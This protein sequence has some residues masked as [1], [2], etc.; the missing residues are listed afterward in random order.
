M[1]ALIFGVGGQDGSYLADLLL[2]KG[3]EVHG[4]YRRTS[5]DNLWRVHH[6]RDSPKLTLHRGDIADLTSVAKILGD[7]LPDEIYNEADQ[8]DLTWSYETPMQSMEVTAGAVAGLL[9][10]TRR[11][12]PSARFFQ[13]VSATMFGSAPG[14][15]TEETPLNPQSPYACA[16]AC[17]YH[18]ARFYR[19]TYGMFVS[20]GILYNHDSPRRGKGRLL[21]QL[22]NQAQEV[23]NETRK[24][25]DVGY[26]DMLVDIGYAPEYV[27]ASWRILKASAPDDFIICSPKTCSVGE[28]ASYALDWIGANKN[29]VGE[30]TQYQRP[31]GPSTLY[32]DCSK[33]KSVTG[34]QPTTDTKGTLGKLHNYRMEVSL[35]GLP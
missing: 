14:P 13:P 27:E 17:A 5:V 10:M 26:P 19:K 11:I 16:K 25:V 24:S 7:V 30:D 22:L 21:G 9:E 8:D 3:Y 31:E 4:V 15:Q 6:L 2:D 29:A 18:L 1:K 35:G 32:G 12:V 33:L 20:T 28:L 34:Y 23:K